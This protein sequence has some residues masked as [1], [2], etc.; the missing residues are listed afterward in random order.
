MADTARDSLAETAKPAAENRGLPALAAGLAVSL[1]IA[2]IA[3]ELGRLVPVVG[4]PIFAIIIG[5]AL[6]NTLVGDRLTYRLRIRDISGYALKTG[7]VVL[8]L[9]LNLSD[10]LTTGASSLAVLAVTVSAGLAFAL[11][12][13][14]GLGMDWRIPCLIGI[15]TTICGASAIAALAPVLR[16]KGEEIAYSISVIFF[17]NMIAV[18]VFPAVGHAFGL[19]DYGFGLWAGTAVNDTSA[20]VAAGFAFSKVA[21]TYATIVKL[22]RTTLIVPLVLSFGLALPWLDPRHSPAVGSI[23][24]AR[25]RKAIPLFIG[26]FL[27]ASVINTVGLIGDAAQNIQLAARF[28]LVLALAAVGLQGNWRAF[29]GAGFRPLALGLGTWITVAIACLLVQYWGGQL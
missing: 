20:V 11:L 12:V 14:R 8:G 15:G 2:L 9:T 21:G 16:A 18:F 10:V 24:S 6:A 5:V 27:L 13:G 1:I 4:A 17:F 23:L 19:S 25:I 22:T 26:L 28:I 3:W 29:A 7:I